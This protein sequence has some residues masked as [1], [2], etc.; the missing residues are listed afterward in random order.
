MILHRTLLVSPKDLP[1]SLQLIL[2]RKRCNTCLKKNLKIKIHLSRRGCKSFW[3]CMSLNQ[4]S[5][6][7]GLLYFQWSLNELNCRTCNS[8]QCYINIYDTTDVCHRFIHFLRWGKWYSLF[9]NCYCFQCETVKY[10]RYISLTQGFFVVVKQ[11]ISAQK[12]EEVSAHYC[13]SLSPKAF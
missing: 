10:A 12:A 1:P 4:M 8:Y 9:L 6:L 2:R 11:Q 7:W 3:A 5:T 13:L